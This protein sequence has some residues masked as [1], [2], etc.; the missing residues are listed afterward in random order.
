[1]DEFYCNEYTNYQP[2]AEIN[3]LTICFILL[4]IIPLSVLFTMISVSQ[5]MLLTDDLPPIEEEKETS[6]SD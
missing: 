2:N 3:P 4:S 5:T 6:N 1:M